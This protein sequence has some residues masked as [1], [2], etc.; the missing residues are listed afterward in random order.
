VALLS[1]MG[2]QTRGAEFDL[3]IPQGNGSFVPVSVTWDTPEVVAFS[4]GPAR[5]PP[6]P[7]AGLTAKKV[8]DRFSLGPITDGDR[9]WDEPSLAALV[10]A[11]ESLAPQELALVKGLGFRRAR[12]SARHLALYQ[13]GDDTNLIDVYDAAFALDGEQFVGT[14]EGP[15]AFLQAAQVHELGHAIA[16]ARMRELGQANLPSDGPS[17][18]RRPPTSQPTP[19]SRRPTRR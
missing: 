16:D 19:S 1:L 5:M 17:R 4:S 11:L 9:T 15:R 8:V 6:P 14:P 18:R 7:T 13:R 12:A 10:V 2:R 3:L